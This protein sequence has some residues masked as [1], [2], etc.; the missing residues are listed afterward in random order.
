MAWFK[1]DDQIAFHQK[2][3]DAGNEAF[4]AWVRMGAWSSARGL[5]GKVT[6]SAAM[7]ICVKQ[8]LIDRLVE[9]KFLD[10]DGA[11]YAIHDYLEWNPPA[12]EIEVKRAK[13]AA[14]GRRG[15]IRSGEA[16]RSKNEANSEANAS[17]KPKQM[18]KQTRSKSEAKTNPVPVPSASYEAE[19][20]PTPQ[21]TGTPPAWFSAAW[22]QQ[23]RIMFVG[24]G[25]LVDAWENVSRYA[26]A[27]GRTAEDV[28]PALL[29]AYES[30]S[31]GWEGKHR[32]QPHLFVRHFDAVQSEAAKARPPQLNQ[33]PLVGTPEFL[34]LPLKDRS[35]IRE[36]ERKRNAVAAIQDARLGQQ[37]LFS[38]PARGDA[39]GLEPEGV[40]DF[41]DRE[42]VS[43]CGAANRPPGGA[44][45]VGN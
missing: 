39:T 44:S 22:C 45:G 6:A 29:G 4:G 2:V 25:A 21:K 19:I 20:P 14:A 1:I 27:A 30:I 31:S 10:R 35:R 28:T 24:S 7:T 43:G 13:R 11:D 26:Q 40:R 15:G 3:L 8:K 34:A 17:A 37:G 41:L 38:D 9:V 12:D 33:A 42:S 36:E 16:R 32:W 5:N 23:A 18:L